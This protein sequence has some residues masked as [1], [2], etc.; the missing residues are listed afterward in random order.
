[1]SCWLGRSPTILRREG[2]ALQKWLAQ[3]FQA[4]VM[5]QMRAWSLPSMRMGP[6]PVPGMHTILSQP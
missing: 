3:L 4:R 5:A 2:S 1:M 6:A